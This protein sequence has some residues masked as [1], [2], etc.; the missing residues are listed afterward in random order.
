MFIGGHSLGA[1]R[2]VAYAYAR[3]VRGLPVDGIYVFGCPRPGNRVIPNALINTPIFRSI[4][5]RRDLVTCVPVDLEFLNEEYVDAKK[6]EETNEA[7]PPNDRWGPFKDHHI[8][9]YQKGCRTLPA[10]DGAAL[11]LIDAVDAVADLYE[12]SSTHWDWLNA[13]D[14][15][16]WGMRDY[17]DA[18]FLVARGSTTALD[19][20]DDFDATEID[21]LGARISA[22][23]WA[24]VGPIMDRL[25]AALLR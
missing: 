15:R 7:A 25:D 19:W 2:G 6:F 16:Y 4:K 23:F 12:A 21:V 14:G 11:S 3:V 9:L 22:G 24:G 8:Q 18:R 10:I 13:E 20:V 1:S 17:P 5:N